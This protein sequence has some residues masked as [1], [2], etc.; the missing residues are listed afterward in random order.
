MPHGGDTQLVPLCT[1][2][3]AQRLA[4]AP[5]GANILSVTAFLH[6]QQSIGH[7]VHQRMQMMLAKNAQRLMSN[8]LL[9]VVLYSLSG[10]RLTAMGICSR[11]ISTAHLQVVLYSHQQHSADAP[12]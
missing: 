4:A 3:S 9:P 2:V 7:Q 1:E 6:W 5:Q 12:S 11:V 10:D 8:A